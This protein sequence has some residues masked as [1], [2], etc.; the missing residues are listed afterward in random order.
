MIVVFL[1]A[2]DSSISTE[3]LFQKISTDYKFTYASLVQETDSSDEHKNEKEKS[4]L[5][6]Y[7]LGI[8]ILIAAGII[9]KQRYAQYLKD[10]NTLN[11]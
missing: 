10:K 11:L 1:S 4:D 2:I 6:Y 5:F 8:V 3:L 7:I 9:F